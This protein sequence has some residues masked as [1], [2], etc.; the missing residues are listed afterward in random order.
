M[1]QKPTDIAGSRGP[2][3]KAQ[4]MWARGVLWDYIFG[5]VV[6]LVWA[7]TTY[8]TDLPVLL[9]GV[10]SGVRRPV[11]QTIATVAGAMGGLTFTSVSIMI[12]LIKTPLSTLDR[13]TPPEDK[14]RVGDVFLAVLPKL[15][16]TF[17]FALATLSTDTGTSPGMF[18]LQALTVG[19]ALASLS[20][21]ARVIWILKRLLKLA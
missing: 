1:N 2:C 15:F 3:K 4:L 7:V 18:W 8:L 17:T 10:D 5:A 20:G 12:N 14:R 16:L 13:L 6:V 11:F 21:L 9:T 19:F